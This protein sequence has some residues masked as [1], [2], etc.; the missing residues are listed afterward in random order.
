[1]SFP[2][3]LKSSA[4]Y[5][6]GVGPKRIQLLNKLNIQTVEDLLYYFPRRHED[7]S[8]LLSIN[9][10]QADQPYT[11]KGE[12]LTFGIF[13]TKTKRMLV[14]EMA[15]GDKTGVIY[16]VWFN[17][18][19]LRKFFKVGQKIIIYGKVQKKGAKLQIINPEYEILPGEDEEGESIH[20]GR[21]V[22]IYPLTQDIRQKNI[23]LIAKSGLEGFLQYI[24]DP[25]PRYLKNKLKLI[26][27]TPAIGNYHFPKTLITL[28]NAKRRLIFDEFFYLQIALALRRSKLKF[29]TK[30]IIHKIDGALLNRFITSLPF[31]LTNSQKKVIAHIKTDMAAARPM[32]RL[33][34][35]E[36]GSGKTVVA[37][38]GL[39]IAVQGGYQAAV[40]APTEILAEQHYRTFT[41]LLTPLGIKVVFISSSLSSHARLKVQNEIKSGTANLIIGTHSLIQK[42]VKFKNLGL[43]IVD[44]QHRFGVAQRQTL[45]NKGLNPD[46]LVMTATPIPRTLALTAYGDLDISIID[47]LPPGRGTLQ[48][49]WVEEDKRAEIYEL[50]KDQVKKGRQVFV[51]YP[52]VEES[53]RQDLK[54]ATKMHGKFQKEIFPDLKVGLV[55]GRLSADKKQQAMKG[56]RTGEIDIL[57]ST[58]V[59]EVGIDMPNATCIVIEHADRFGLAQLHQLR[60]RIARSKH[61]S[62]CV[63]IADAITEA[64]EKRLKTM[65]TTQNGFKIA[66]ADLE[67]R[68]PGD[69]FGT[70]QHGIPELKIGNLSLD[71]KILEQAKQ[72]AFGL[73]KS[74]LGLSKQ[75]HRFIKSEIL[76]KYAT[77]GPFGI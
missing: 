26:D 65:V 68:G 42:D 46:V 4:Q 72:E 14:F 56:F 60:G 58:I 10:L 77:M 22:P 75:E 37:C 31:E 44:E 57:V 64:A 3:P 45:T 7:R 40:M 61:A 19:F 36:V 76:K 41:E 16:C 39:V 6:K 69:F 23:R 28:E 5:I 20:T 47:E 25:L 52:L 21:I 54:D 35:G 67:I 29:K 15:V 17:Q 71:V 43:A 55:H 33:L 50:I 30:G 59:V 11:I 38:S 70:R 34:Q 12:I 63:L 74:D 49:V 18:P 9:K 13:K 32:Y 66:Q 53:L 2:N 27:L 73:V 24:K 62:Y 1:M 48:T 8:R 51:I